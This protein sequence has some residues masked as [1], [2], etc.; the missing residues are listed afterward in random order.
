MAIEELQGGRYQYLRVLGSGGMGEVY[1]MQDTRVNRQVAIKVVRAEG[2]A[3]ADSQVTANS[4]R[5]FEREAKA[6]AALEHPNILPLYD[7]GEEKREA[8]NVTYMVMPYCPDGSLENWLHRHPGRFFSPKT[9][10][11]LVEQAA[12]ALQ[13]AHDHQVVH[14]DVKPSNFLIRN[15]RKDAERPTLLL[16]DFGIARNFTTI[17]SSSQ[18]IRGTP[19]AMAPEQ[20]SSKPVLASDQ[21]A[22]AIM[23]YELLAGRPPFTGSMEQLLYQ[24][25][26]VTPPTPRQF[27]PRLSASLDPVLLRALAKKPAERFPSIADFA[28]ALTLAANQPNPDFDGAEDDD[29]AQYATIT[30]SQAEADAGLSRMLTLTDDQELI[31]TIE[32][33]ARDGQIIRVPH[34][35]QADGQEKAVFVNIAVQPSEAPHVSPETPRIVKGELH[36]EQGPHTPA[37]K[38]SSAVLTDERD[39]PTFISNRAEA[40][41]STD[42]HDLPTIASSRPEVRVSETPR[43]LPATT[44]KQRTGLIAAVSVLVVL[45]LIAGT[46]YFALGRLRG[47]AQGQQTPT[48]AATATPSPTPTIAPGLDIADTYNGSILNEATGQGQSLTLKI[49]QTRGQGVVSGW[50]TFNK[51]QTY[52]LKGT[53]DMQGNFGFTVQQASGQ[54]PLY[55]HGTVIHQP[56]GNILKGY[57]CNSSTATCPTN[58]GYFTVGPGYAE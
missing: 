6:I 30:I 34:P 10:A 19:A 37:I 12:E 44:P 11:Y 52:T 21:Y 53:V 16:A 7:F 58:T 48:V 13:Y 43:P 23:A 15:N 50:A 29:T 2:P 39:L 33:G 35:D 41:S 46:T 28:D 22:L 42:E 40:A 8:D 27:N 45:A 26:T 17:S 25:L 5:L 51:S 56:N 54:M 38:I 57:Y 14:L 4:A 49:Q 36:A 32:A 24:H 55:L 3:A 1:L 9:V 18:T 31:V 20:W 47:Q